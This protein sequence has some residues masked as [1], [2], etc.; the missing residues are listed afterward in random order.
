VYVVFFPLVN[1]RNSVDI[2]K[3]ICK[4]ILVKF[5]DDIPRYRYIIFIL[6][7]NS[8]EYRVHLNIDLNIEFQRTGTSII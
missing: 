4:L 3:N 7:T 1:N 5:D 8:T 6:P 2:R